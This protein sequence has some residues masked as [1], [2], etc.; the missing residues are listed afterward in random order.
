[1]TISS[2]MSPLTLRSGVEVPNRIVMAPMVVLAADKDSGAVSEEMLE[3]FRLR[4]EVA[5]MIITESAY[6]TED[7]KG[8]GRQLS[9][10]S[11]EMLSGLT[12]LAKTLKKDGA[13]AVIQLHHGG[14][15]ALPVGEGGNR[16]VAPS[17]MEFEW[18]SF[19]PEEMTEEDIERII[20][21]FA[22][23]TRRALEAGFDGVEV[24]GANHYLLQQFFSPFSNRREDRW[25]GDEERR[26]AFP[27]AVL[28]A[29][30]DEAR[31]ADR[32][33]L[34]GYRI[35]P[36]EIHG[37]TVGY[38][39]DDSLA[40]ID[41]VAGRH[42]D[43]LHLSLYEGYDCGPEDGRSFGKLACI[44]VAGRC[45]V[46]VVGEIFTEEDAHK[47]LEFGDL[48][49]L[50]RAA[51]IE[52]QFARKIAEGRGEEIEISVAGRLDTLSF[53]KDL[54]EWFEVSGKEYLPPLPGI[55]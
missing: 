6:V 20:A 45:P 36:D 37:D 50:G 23:A 26:M 16:T 4:S 13:A 28:D 47:A 41:A 52:P 15:E 53:P 17:A 14:R 38:T 12:A 27:L 32:P 22:Q 39:I 54:T 10:T 51:L 1:M 8:F 21:A 24:H 7:G 34:V 46:I 5:G 25:G 29:V 33:F 35:S 18:L 49:A 48:V 30:L 19:D 11:D 2:L 44:T 42:V 40:L 31:Q 43:Y 3:Y 9:I 55:D